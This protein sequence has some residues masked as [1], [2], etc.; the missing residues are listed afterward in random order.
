M[1]PCRRNRAFS[2]LLLAIDWAFE[3][4][5]LRTITGGCGDV[6]LLCRVF[7]CPLILDFDVWICGEDELSFSSGTGRVG[8]VDPAGAWVKAGRSWSFW[9]RLETGVCDLESDC[10]WIICDASFTVWARGEWIW[11]PEVP[12][13]WGSIWI[14]TCGITMDGSSCVVMCCFSGQPWR[15]LVLCWGVWDGLSAETWFGSWVC[16]ITFP[17][18][19]TCLVLATT[20]NPDCGC[21]CIWSV[22]SAGRRNPR[23][24]NLP[25]ISWKK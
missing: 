22:V 5:S 9:L 1:R 11:H 14:W 3:W 24:P 20:K 17:T 16:R 12:K 21:V 8:P 4:T 7:G 15:P 25:R 2:S 18:W 13:C 10:G 6:L 19:S 23:E